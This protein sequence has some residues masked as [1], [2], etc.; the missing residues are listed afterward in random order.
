[1]KKIAVILLMFLYLI[2]AIGVKVSAH[3]C[4]GKITSVSIKLLDFGHKCPCGNKPMKKDC[5]K[6]EA[7]TFK[8]KDEHQKAIQFTLK[9]FKTFTNAPILVYN[10]LFSFKEPLISDGHLSYTHPPDN[11]KH[12]LYIRHSVFRI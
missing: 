11:T 10:F 7:K 1:M 8:L 6:D 2:P 4:G 3:H 9:G 12:P 5:C